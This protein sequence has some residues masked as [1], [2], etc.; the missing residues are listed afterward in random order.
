MKKYNKL[1]WYLLSNFNPENTNIQNLNNYGNYTWVTGLQ[2]PPNLLNKYHNY[3]KLED[4][5]NKINDLYSY[6]QKLQDKLEEKEDEIGKKD[7]INRKLSKEL[8]NRTAK[9]KE[10]NFLNNLNKSNSNQ[11]IM[12][13]KKN[14]NSCF[15][16]LKKNADKYNLLDKLNDY[17]TKDK[18]YNNIINIK[19]K[20]S[21][22]KDNLNLF[23]ND[24]IED[25]KI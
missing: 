7:F 23:G 13:N 20:T 4:D 18:K 6:I 2:L 25:E 11:N 1:T 9:I 8:Q 14:A 3:N 10:N 15:D 5:E 12:I 17:D 24:S 16:E 22:I 21:N 19:T